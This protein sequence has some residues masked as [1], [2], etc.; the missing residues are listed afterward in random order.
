MKCT[1][2]E[3]QRE[4]V[5]KCYKAARARNES[6][7]I[8]KLIKFMGFN[9]ERRDFQKHLNLENTCMRLAIMGYCNNE[10]CQKMEDR[11]HQK[12][13]LAISKKKSSKMD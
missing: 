11:L 1:I 12:K 5:D 4:L 7:N 6:F 9:G 10:K 3:D 2:P 8:T 13:L